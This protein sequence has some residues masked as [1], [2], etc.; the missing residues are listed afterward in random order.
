[1][2]R[3]FK[4]NQTGN[5][6]VND[7]IAMRRRLLA[8]VFTTTDR[9][10]TEDREVRV[11]VRPRDESPFDLQQYPAYAQYPDIVIHDDWVGDLTKAETVV[12]LLGFNYHEL[13]HNMFTPRF[14]DVKPE[15]QEAWEILEDARIE[16]LFTAL[17][18]PAGKY[19]TQS[20]IR[21][22]VNDPSQYESAFLSSY[23]RSYLPKEIR[24]EFEA[25][26][27]RQDLLA[28]AKKHIDQ[29]KK[30]TNKDFIGNEKAVKRTIHNFARVLQ[31][32][33]NGGDSIPN[34]ACNST[35]Q[36]HL[37][38]ISD[39]EEEATQ[40]EN[41][42]RRRERRTG[43]DQSNFWEE[44]DE[45]EQE[46]GDDE[47]EDGEGDSSGEDSEDDSNDGDSAADGDTEDSDDADGNSGSG[48]DESSENGEGD[49]EGQ[50]EDSESSGNDA[51]SGGSDADS[52]GDE[53]EDGEDGD[54]GDGE[55]DNGS[56]SDLDDEGSDGIGSTPG[57]MPEF[58]E[59]ELKDYLD[60][61]VEAVN[62]DEAVA[63]EVS[64]ILAA[65]NDTATI[66][67]I[68][69]DWSA[70]REEPVS[71]SMVQEAERIGGE[72]RRLYAEVEP[73]W[74]YG[75]DVGK[76]NV[77]RAMLSDDYDDIFDEWD[78]GRESDIGL[79]VVIL[80]DVSGSMGGA[81]IR[82][83]SKNLW[84]IKRGLDTQESK[85]TVLGFGSETVGMYSREEHVD[86]AKWKLWPAPGGSTL[87]AECFVLARRILEASDMPNKLT[88]IL[89]DGGWHDQDYNGH[90]L[91]ELIQ[92]IPGT[93]I[94]IGIGSGI[95]ANTSYK[96][97][98]DVAAE[99]SSPTGLAELV[100][101]AVV[102]LLRRRSG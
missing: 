68:D 59:E 4:I 12:G 92:A 73:G 67:V 84:C 21:V 14:F 79:E 11:H 55:G 35:E 56:D 89:T 62:Q 5:S 75:S 102:D 38:P 39:K 83:A 82:S 95:Y 28:R 64:R 30:Y 23:G 43:K 1:M 65:V 29:F 77:G 91:T 81:D 60:E 61:I 19:F 99:M 27:C 7:R 51:N 22:F 69:F 41:E 53:D 24:D 26:F 101:M 16:S 47:N 50:E 76:L 40:Q 36:E 2:G 15:D 44:D 70:Q 46:D 63:N 48:D 88:V 97:L 17:Y 74:L 33:K 42:R 86:A 34:A 80:T 58:D 90:S 57:P 45:D 25:R 6:A 3:I 10:L 52:E 72:L 85:V 49:S 66:D 96:Q 20:F 9:I 18:E 94:Y 32:I 78:E 98:F 87:P 8:G 31:E 54:A 93:K 100:R 37:G 71:A 13:A